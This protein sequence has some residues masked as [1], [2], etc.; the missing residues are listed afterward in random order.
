[1]VS[2]EEVK[3]VEEDVPP[4]EIAHEEQ[5]EY[6]SISEATILDAMEIEAVAANME[7]ASARGHLEALV[8]KLR[9]DGAALKRV[10]QSRQ[11][12]ESTSISKEF[13]KEVDVGNGVPAKT[14]VALPTSKQTNPIVSESAKYTPIDR[15]SFDAGG[16]NSQF[17]TIYIP[18]P[19]VG[20]SI[21]RD[22]IKCSFTKDSFDLIVT[23]LNG[24][25]YR[26]YNNNLE[27][28]IITEKSKYIVKSDKIII[29][30]A[31]VKGEYGSYD[32]WNQ[33]SAKKGKKEKEVQK[34][35]PSGAI[36]DLM[37]DM[38]DSGDDQMKKMIGETM[39]KQREG[40][41]DSQMDMGAGLGN[42]F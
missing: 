35:N 3:D 36:M 25:N 26:L 15:F 33:L 18:L 6:V 30:L 1:M 4:N 38:Y 23:E 42:Q 21:L 13:T 12:M 40:K 32:S 34:G 29:K 28:E 31:K 16:Y 11:K 24:K 2:V 17:V 14:Q 27:K 9:L 10:E 5:Q 39:L 7:R 37:K 8:K 19:N 41:A 20:A 22:N